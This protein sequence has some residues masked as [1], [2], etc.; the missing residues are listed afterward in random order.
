MLKTHWIC[1]YGENKNK[2]NPKAKQKIPQWNKQTNPT[3]LIMQ[4]R[5]KSLTVR[6]QYYFST[7]IPLFGEVAEWD[8]LDRVPRDK[9]LEGKRGLRKLISVLESPA[10]SSEAMLPKHKKSGKTARRPAWVKKEL[11]AKLKHSKESH[12]EW[13]QGQVA[14]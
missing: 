1:F 4:L 12:R 5:T 13:K 7:G 14:W 11:L 3:N 2:G 10:A 9:A 6:S 8:L